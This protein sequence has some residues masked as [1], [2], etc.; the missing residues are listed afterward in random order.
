MQNSK[1]CWARMCNPQ[2]LQSKV[3]TINFFLSLRVPRLFAKVQCFLS[4]KTMVLSHHSWVTKSRITFL[5]LK[6]GL[7]ILGNHSVVQRSKPASCRAMAG[8]LLADLSRLGPDNHFTDVV[9]TAQG[10]TSREKTM[11]KIFPL[12]KSKK[13]TI[14][15]SFS[16]F[17][18]KGLALVFTKGGL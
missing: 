4:R 3:A 12:W 13:T 18:R 9:L 6:V 15:W 7:S 11:S 17:P 8:S 16:K 14:Y 10:G 2:Y 5:V 1:L